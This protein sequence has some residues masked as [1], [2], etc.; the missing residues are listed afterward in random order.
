MTLKTELNLVAKNLIEKTFESISVPV[1]IEPIT[2]VYDEE[3]GEI[4]SFEST[5]ITV[6]AIVGPFTSTR[7]ETSSVQVNDLQAIIAVLDND[8]D[9]ILQN[10]HFQVGTETYLAVSKEIDASDSVIILQLRKA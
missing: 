10:D 4:I 7:A 8:T 3:S 5:N 1:V 6:K 9:A 2:T